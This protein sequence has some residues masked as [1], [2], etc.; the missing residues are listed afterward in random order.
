MFTKLIESSSVENVRAGV[1]PIEREHANVIVTRVAPN[2]WSCSNGGHHV[3]FG[4]FQGNAKCRT[5]EL[6]TRHAHFITRFEEGVAR[7]C[8]GQ[9]R[10]LETPR[11]WQDFR[12]G[13]QEHD[14]GA[15]FRRAPGSF[16]R[17]ATR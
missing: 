15:R 5:S 7:R 14:R 16:P 6:S 11:G 17:M 2:H 10:V 9:L 3:N 12:T 13:D 8:F 1:G 4:A